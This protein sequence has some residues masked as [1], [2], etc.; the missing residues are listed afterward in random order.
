MPYTSNVRFKGKKKPPPR[1]APITETDER[2]RI[3]SQTT[4]SEPILS[5]SDYSMASYYDTQRSQSLDQGSSYGPHTNYATAGR[6]LSVDD[7]ASHAYQVNDQYWA[8]GRYEIS[9]SVPAPSG[10]PAYGYH[11]MAPP[12]STP[13]T[14]SDPASNSF[15]YETAGTNQARG[16]G[17]GVHDSNQDS[18][19]G[20][21]PYQSSGNTAYLSTPPLEHAINLQSSW[22]YDRSKPVSSVFTTL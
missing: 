18:E 16:A 5:S 20:V 9:S 17:Y 12:S 13:L 22:S 1:P 10:T 8:G 2:E 15:E 21:G 11:P 6:S 14:R 19:G 3:S 4:H 7:G